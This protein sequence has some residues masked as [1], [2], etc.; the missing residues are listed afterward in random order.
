MSSGLGK[1][2]LGKAAPHVAL[3]TQGQTQ[4]IQGHLPVSLSTCLSTQHVR[5]SGRSWK[6]RTR[7]PVHKQKTAPR[8]RGQGAFL[9]GL[10]SFQRP[11][12]KQLQLCF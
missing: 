2:G 7:K 9:D 8:A 3:G 1:A 6:G 4:G 5:L 11:V 10:A 12:L